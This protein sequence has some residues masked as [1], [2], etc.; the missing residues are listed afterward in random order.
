ML[1]NSPSVG[2]CS[3]ESSSQEL[4]GAVRVVD[5]G[6]SGRLRYLRNQSKQPA[7]AERGSR[8]WVATGA[9]YWVKMEQD[10]DS[11][12]SVHVEPDLCRWSVLHVHLP[13]RVVSVLIA[14]SKL[15]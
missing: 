15:T 2:L 1:G 13:I 8:A 10:P 11:H 3:E 7:V 14:T 6:Q 4:Q 9:F 5:W 12:A